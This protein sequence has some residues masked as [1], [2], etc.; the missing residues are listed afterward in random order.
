[1]SRS[2][3]SNT[4]NRYD[5]AESSGD[6]W[7]SYSE[8]ADDSAS[9]QSSAQ[10]Q[11]LGQTADS[12]AEMTDEQYMEEAP[13]KYDEASFWIN[14]R[15]TVDDLYDQRGNLKNE[16]KIVLSLKAGDF[17][18]SDHTNPED[19]KLDE[20]DLPPV[21]TPLPH[22]T[23]LD[24]HRRGPH[25]K[26]HHHHQRKHKPRKRRARRDLFK[27]A[28]LRAFTTNW[29]GPLGVALPTVRALAGEGFHHGSDVVTKV[30][31]HNEISAEQPR[32]YEIRVRPVTKGMVVFNN[33]YA[34]QTVETYKEAVTVNAK[35]GFA[36]VPY[37]SPW[38]MYHNASEPLGSQ[39]NGPS[40]GFEASGMIHVPLDTYRKY[41]AVTDREMR[42]KLS[43]ADVTDDLQ[44]EFFVPM[45][46]GL[47]V[48]EH[49]KFLE[50]GQGVAWDNFAD[51]KSQ[52]SLAE[53]NASALSS[54][55]PG[56]AIA[57]YQKNEYYLRGFLDMK[58]LRCNGRK[59]AMNTKKMI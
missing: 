4:K 29:G 11:R 57:K 14:K 44:I 58:Y 13:I 5:S 21:Q 50:T 19:F 22:Q 59:I 43:M 2:Q 40:V 49:A 30:F 12:S 35:Q 38:V 51:H 17:V 3:T 42:S 25:R 52:L 28:H 37:G 46:T 56:N 34:G 16:G 8:E 20:L 55:Q 32:N 24:A 1:M 6:F 53:L 31:A 18:L 7:D 15:F 10:Q 9:L 48:K 47:R 27:S 39:F 45:E 41:E 23:A 26:P 36:L 33:R 54:G